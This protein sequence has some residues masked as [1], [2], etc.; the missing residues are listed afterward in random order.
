MLTLKYR[1]NVSPALLCRLNGTGFIRT[2]R[3][4][5]RIFLYGLL[6]VALGQLIVFGPRKNVHFGSYGRRV[7]RD[8]IVSGRFTTAN[9]VINTR[10]AIN[11]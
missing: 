1:N 10:L 4:V 3:N 11:P 5:T 6:R 8:S 9:V 7:L 2:L